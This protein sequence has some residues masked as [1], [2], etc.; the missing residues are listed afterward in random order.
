MIQ[1]Y[2]DEISRY[3]S[4]V[5]AL[6]VMRR[7]GDMKGVHQQENWLRGKRGLAYAEFECGYCLQGLNVL[8][9]NAIA[10]GQSA[11]P[12]AIPAVALP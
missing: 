6:E 9:S 1:P 11:A 7:V 12:K 8:D 2:L 3:Q 4:R 10:K 5:V